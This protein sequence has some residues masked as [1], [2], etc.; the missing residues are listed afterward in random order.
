MVTLAKS[1][2]DLGGDL[3]DASKKFGVAAG[4]LSQLQY[5]AKVLFV[6]LAI[7]PPH[8]PAA[9]SRD[10]RVVRV[11]DRHC[12]LLHQF[13]ASRRRQV[14]GVR[15]HLAFFDAVVNL[16]P[17]EAGG[18]IAEFNRQCSEIESAFSGLLVVA[19]EAGPRDERPEFR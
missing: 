5:V 4:E 3:S 2:I 10:F 15:R 19:V 8:R 12:Q 1:A 9:V 18:E 17:P 13:R 7:Q 14:I 6:L 11:V 16:N